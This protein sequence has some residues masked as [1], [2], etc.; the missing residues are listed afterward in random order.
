[1][2]ETRKKEENHQLL[3]AFAHARFYKKRDLNI[4][5]EILCYEYGNNNKSKKKLL[6]I[7]ISYIILCFSAY[8]EN[9]YLYDMN[10]GLTSNLNDF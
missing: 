5:F 8:W 2:G 6:F 3:P 1:M 7:L 9:V 10:S 4:Y